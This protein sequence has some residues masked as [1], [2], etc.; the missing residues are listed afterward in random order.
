[1]RVDAHTQMTPYSHDRTSTRQD[2]RPP[3]A[4]AD[5][6]LGERLSQ[7]DDRLSDLQR[8]RDR[9]NADDEEATRSSARASGLA[10]GFR[11]SS[12]F[13]GSII[14]GSALGW[15]IDHVLPTSPWGMIISILVGF[16]VG[17]LNLIRATRGK[18][19]E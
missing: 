12:E 2:H 15:C 5:T 14:V 6:T 7:L 10:Y 17:L 8:D 11:I 3:T 19:R 1:M 4:G 16:I 18:D 13:I 9:R